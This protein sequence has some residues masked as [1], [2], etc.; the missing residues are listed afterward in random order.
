MS[1]HG[2]TT[3]RDRIFASL[4]YLVPLVTS[5]SFSSNVFQQFPALAKVVIPILSPVLLIYS[6]LPFANLIIFFALFFLVVRNEKI[7]HFIR[8]NTMQALL[9]DI[10]LFIAALILPIL[11]QVSGLNLIVVALSSVVFLGTLTIVIFA[12]VQ[13]LRGLYAEVPTLSE[14]VY[15]QVR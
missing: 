5:L 14:A 3:V 2:S 1:W 11:T 7:L 15:M 9:V 10:L 4:P 12:V 8:F 13:S 6:V